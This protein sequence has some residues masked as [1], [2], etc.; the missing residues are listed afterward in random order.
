MDSDPAVLLRAGVELFN[1]GKFLA[2]HEL[3]EELWESTHDES[4][5]F[6]KGLVQACIC[7]YHYSEGNGD[8]ARKLYRGHRRCLG[9]YLPHHAGLDVARLLADMQVALEPVLRAAPGTPL[10]LAAEDAPRL[11]AAPAD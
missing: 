1:A 4:S 8:G 2:S 11:H 3:F 5:E 9:S 6:Y 7:L 10:T